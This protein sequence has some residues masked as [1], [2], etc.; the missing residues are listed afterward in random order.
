MNPRLNST[1]LRKSVLLFAVIG[2]AALSGALWMTWNLVARA[3]HDS[4]LTSTEASNIAITELFVNEAWQDVRVL[5]PASDASVDAI[6]GNPHLKKID[7]R[8]RRFERG[9]D[10]VKVKIFDLKGR[11]VYSSDASQL[12]EDKSGNAGYRSAREGKQ[13]SE[14]TFRGKFNS[15]DGELTDRNLVSS[16]TPVRSLGGIEAVVEIYTDRTSSLHHTE[17][18]LRNLLL[19]L[20]P[21]FLAVYFGLLIF[22]RSAERAKQV[23]EESLRNLAA[24]SA[25]ARLAAEQ[26]NAGKST[27]LATMSHEIRTP[28]NGVIGMA[29]L[30]L[31]TPLSAEQRDFADNIAVSGESLLAIINDI[32]DLSK[33]EAEHMEFDVHPFALGKV[34]ESVMS[35]LGFRAQEKGI[36][37]TAKLQPGLASGYAGDST[38]IRQVLLNLAGNAIKFTESGEVAVMVA[39]SSKGLRFEVRDSGIG[40]APEVIPRLFT[41][42]TQAETSTT[43]RFGGT[44]LGLAI[45]KR[46]V[47]GMGGSI[48][49][50]SQSGQGSCFWFELPLKPATLPELPMASA[51]VEVTETLDAIQPATS[52]SMEAQTASL[53]RILLVEDHPI[54]QKLALTLI[55]RLGYD[56]DLA[57]NGQEAVDVTATTSYQLVLMDM[58]MPVM[59][60][61]EATRRIRASAG[62]CA[63]VP[64]VALTANAMQADRETC[65]AAGMDDFLGK[66]F[67]RSDLEAL[68]ARWLKPGN[69]R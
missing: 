57:E 50:E 55:K 18:H 13:A 63:Q 66:P 19:T 25:A 59:D 21:V 44:G 35:L 29:K 10:I 2:F 30:L 20:V 68:L 42:F 56:V 11:T 58:Q 61:I 54:N 47:E 17:M 37:F 28:M 1:L 9:T 65:K 67:A 16:Y 27:F 6:K 49:V 7:E 34:V 3:T 33:I 38:R 5:L 39:S 4:V 69:E 52:T 64:I 46:L 60:G 51:A 40:I 48:G 8:V 41:N 53:A 32:L 36:A 14:M 15:F 45:S 12:G 43:R 31:D 23:H 22:V 62:P 26:A 24:E